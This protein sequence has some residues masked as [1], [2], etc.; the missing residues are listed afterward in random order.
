MVANRACKTLKDNG[1]P[2][3]A[4]PLQDGDFCF[5]HSPEH[6]PEMREARR[7]GGLR[8]RRERTVTSAYDVDGFGTIAQ[9]QRVLEIVII[10]GLGLENTVARGRL[11]VAAILAGAKLQETGELADQLGAIKGV[12]EARLPTTKRHR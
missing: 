4:P 12:L 8:R 2:C 10:D 5:A 3:R 7:L 1:E 11:L 9:L 6:A